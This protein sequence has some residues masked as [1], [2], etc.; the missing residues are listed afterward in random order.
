MTGTQQGSQRAPT[1]G[2][3]ALPCLHNQKVH[4]KQ[5]TQ[6]TGREENCKQIVFQPLKKMERKLQ[7]LL[8]GKKIKESAQAHLTVL[9]FALLHFTA[10][11]VCMY[12]FTYLLYKL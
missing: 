11:M 7:S 9:H 8:G 12:L 10:T 5:Y 6:G 2:H 4:K 3:T 1:Q